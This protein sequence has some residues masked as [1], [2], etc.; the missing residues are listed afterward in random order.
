ME[1]K[2]PHLFSEAKLGN[3]TIKNRIFLAPMGTNNNTDGMID[4][5]TIAYYAERA[6]GGTA[7]ISPGSVVVEYPRGAQIPSILRLDQQ[8][9]IAGWQDMA[10]QI[11]RYGALL[12]PQIY[13]GGSS[14]HIGTTQGVQPI[15]VSE[16]DKN[17]MV[18]NESKRESEYHV[19]ETDEVDEI[20]EKYIWTAWYAQKAGCDGVT[21]HG[22]H[23]YLIN[24]FLS[25][26]NNKRTDKWGGSLE[27]RARF[28]VEIIKGIRKK[29]GPNFII[30]V[31]LPVKEYLDDSNAISFEESAEIARMAEAA[32]ADYLD[33]STGYNND[34]EFVLEGT[35]KP[36][37]NRISHAQ[38]L[39]NAVSIPI[40]CVGKLRK[41]EMCEEIIANGSCDFVSMGRTLVC[42]P[43]WPEKVRAGH[44]DEIR[45]C[46]SCSQICS[47]QQVGQKIGC[48]LNPVCGE[49][50]NYAQ[51]K[52]AANPKNIV[53]VGGGLAGMQAAIT[54]K[55][56][57]HHPTIIEK[58]EILGGQMQMA[59]KPP[60]KQDIKR[61]AGWFIGEIERK[62]IPCLMGTEA[63]LENIQALKPDIVFMAAGGTPVTPRILGS[64][65]CH[66]AWEYLREKDPRLLPEGKKVAIIGGGVVGCEIA[67]M[68]MRT[69]CEISI[70]EMFGQLGEALFGMERFN[71]LREFKTYGVNELLNS[72]VVKIEQNKVTYK[73]DGEEFT[74]DADEIILAVG[75]RPAGGELAE[76]L[77]EKGIV[78][79]KIGDANKQGRFVDATR[80]GFY[81]ALDAEFFTTL[82]P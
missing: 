74:V 36:E 7:V 47:E 30:G 18:Y 53:I 10:R 37:G 63:T 6:K 17:V 2:Y 54:A 39:K 3:R 81:A 27:N 32:G 11:H 59:C 52:P 13:H 72:T 58:T 21:L 34:P 22:A 82:A 20:I 79:K 40:V 48:C 71:M 12:I 15:A 43:Y 14:C 16:P 23:K 60:H 65:H 76:Q 49:E 31:R 44:E 9:C 67:E 64:E 1:N 8:R 35:R 42:D 25:R 70:I 28:M 5:R 56:L 62:G 68:L 24:Q 75:V 38:N 69:N 45:Y 50:A 55:E 78:V 19:L 57:G 4:A 77:R 66:Q 80:D 46:L 61:A 51:L 41:P 29:C 26:I 33:A 73:T